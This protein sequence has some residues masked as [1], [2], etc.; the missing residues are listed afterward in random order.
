MSLITQAWIPVIR[1][2]GIHNIIVPW[3]IAEADN[4]VVKINAP[5]PDF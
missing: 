2:N 3:Q 5:R 4:P 1:Q